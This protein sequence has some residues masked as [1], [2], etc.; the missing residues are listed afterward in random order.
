MP[1]SLICIL[2]LVERSEIRISARSFFVFLTQ[3]QVP[4]VMVH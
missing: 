1:I 2:L 4:Q 3:A